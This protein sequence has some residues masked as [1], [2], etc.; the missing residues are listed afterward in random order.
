LTLDPAT[1]GAP[2]LPHDAGSPTRR[3]RRA[4]QQVGPGLTATAAAAER[5]IS[6]SAVRGQLGTGFRRRGAHDRARAV[7]SAMRRRRL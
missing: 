5:G 6:L 3:E 4:G 1:D 7:L 2:A